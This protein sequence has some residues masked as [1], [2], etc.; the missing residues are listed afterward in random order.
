MNVL[1]F[2]EAIRTVGSAQ[3]RM[4]RELPGSRTMARVDIKMLGRSYPDAKLGLRKCEVREPGTT[5]SGWTEPEGWRWVV[6]LYQKLIKSC[7]VLRLVSP[8]VA[9]SL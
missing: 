7:T 9:G 8:P 2:E 4:F 5:L 6:R 3:K 1:Q